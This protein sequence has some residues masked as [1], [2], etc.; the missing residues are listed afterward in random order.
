MD[1]L[2]REFMLPTGAEI[3]RVA[4]KVGQENPI[5]HLHNKYH[6]KRGFKAKVAHVLNTTL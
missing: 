5:K 2:H 3:L 4:E 6:G 1:F